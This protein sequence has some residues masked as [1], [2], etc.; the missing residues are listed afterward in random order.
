[1]KQRC[2]ERQARICKEAVVA[3]LKVLSQ[4]TPEETEETH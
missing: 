4:Y 1:M 2:E 3:Y